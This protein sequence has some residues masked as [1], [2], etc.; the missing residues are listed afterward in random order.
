MTITTH[1][2]PYN[3][4]A[5]THPVPCPL[6]TLLLILGSAYTLH[7]TRSGGALARAYPRSPT[8]YNSVGVHPV[9]IIDE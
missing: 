7:T 5:C 4:T 1:N 8:E 9:K 3:A 2:V 6:A